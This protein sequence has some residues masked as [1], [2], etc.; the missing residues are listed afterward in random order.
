M[1]IT[2]LNFIKQNNII[3]SLIAKQTLANQKLCGI[4][5]LKKVIG[6]PH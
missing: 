1:E 6:T 3:I 5:K 4:K 2:N